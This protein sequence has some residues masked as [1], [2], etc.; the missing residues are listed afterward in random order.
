VQ[1]STKLD[2]TACAITFVLLFA[3]ARELDAHHARPPHHA[4]GWLL[5]MLASAA[6]LLVVRA[7]VRRVGR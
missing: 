4:W 7:A 3:V 1:R 5:A 2:V 6:V